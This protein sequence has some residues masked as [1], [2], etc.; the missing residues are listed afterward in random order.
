MSFCFFMFRIFVRVK[1]FRRLFPDDALVLAAWLMNIGYAAVWQWCG[2]QLYLSIAVASGKLLIPSPEV[3]EQLQTFLHGLFVACYLFYTC[4]W[5][6]KMSFLI[7][8]W[9]LGHNV[10]RQKILWW[11][12]FAITLASYAVCLGLVDYRCLLGSEAHLA[13][14]Y[15]T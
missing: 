12:I 7:F 5:S 11:A 8:F 2:N 9:K 4:L 1:I 15:I 6:I 3:V 14:E 13:S 10:Q